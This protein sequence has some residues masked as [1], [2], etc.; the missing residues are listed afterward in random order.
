MDKEEVKK[1]YRDDLMSWMKERFGPGSIDPIAKFAE[2]DWMLIVKLHAMIETGLNGV[3]ISHFGEPEL[4]RVIAKLDTSNSAGKVAFAKAL[5]IITHN[6]AVLIQKLSEIRNFCVH[7][8]KN[9]DFNLEN[10]ISGLEEGDRKKL[11]KLVDHEIKSGLDDLQWP[12]SALTGAI[13]NI[14]IQLHFHEMKCQ[15]RDMTAQKYKW[16]S[17]ELALLR[18]SMSTE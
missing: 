5:Q 16:D 10:Y 11:R 14:M 2:N 13:V 7:D 17:E 12:G 4:G 3:L 18:Q 9:F 1:R 6:S 15:L 8:I